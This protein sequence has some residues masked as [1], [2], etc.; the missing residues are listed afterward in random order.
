MLPASDGSSTNSSTAAEPVGQGDYVVQKGDCIESIAFEH[1]LFW[2]TV[3][4]HLQN[5]ELKRARKDPNVLLPGDRV[6]LIEK[7]KK[8]EAGD[9]EQKHRFKRKGVPSI[10]RMQLL[11]EGQP[12]ANLKYVLEID[13]ITYTGN[14]D[15]DGRLKQT[16]P[17]NARTAQLKLGDDGQECYT[18]KLRHIDPVSSLTGVQA[19][20]SNIGYDPGPIDGKMRASLEAALTLFQEKYDLKITGE[21][22][23]ATQDKLL[24]VH[25]C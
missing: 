21:P 19:R 9:P 20:L 17:P 11:N 5:A 10:L 15:G 16:L 1:G 4:N 14:T 8:Q 12:R 22:D 13:G 3:W 24:E 2:K 18:L 23:Q 7:R 6:H 25:G